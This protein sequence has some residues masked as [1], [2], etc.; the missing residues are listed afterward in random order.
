MAGE[1]LLQEAFAETG[2]QLDRIIDAYER[3]KK[4]YPYY[5]KFTRD[6]NYQ[7]N[8]FYQ[9]SSDAGID[10]VVWKIN[11]QELNDFE[12]NNNDG[13]FSNSM[14]QYYY[15]YFYYSGDKDDGPFYHY[16]EDDFE[17]QEA[18]RNGTMNLDFVDLSIQDKQF[19]KI[20]SSDFSKVEFC[21]ALEF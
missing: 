20:N 13:P 3:K 14:W 4:D 21:D 7:D 19:I 6:E 11:S 18:A 1:S 17:N 9:W 2:V 15:G 12:S 8:M 5:I 16:G 10:S